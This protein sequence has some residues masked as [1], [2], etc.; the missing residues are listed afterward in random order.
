MEKFLPVVVLATEF[1]YADDRRFFVTFSNMKP[2]KKTCPA[3][4]AFQVWVK[5]H[6]CNI[7]RAVSKLLF[8]WRGRRADSQGF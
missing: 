4:L 6:Y 7:N 5:I 3:F 1:W 2:G 8:F